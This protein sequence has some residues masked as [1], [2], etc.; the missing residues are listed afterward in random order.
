M[1]LKLDMSKTYDRVELDF[2]AVVLRKLCFDSRMIHL[3]LQ[4]ITSSSFS[5]LVNG[6]T[7]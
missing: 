2:V 7:H 3:I 6:S 4:F 5:V 1:A